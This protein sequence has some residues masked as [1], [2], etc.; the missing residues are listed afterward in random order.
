MLLGG[1]N[2]NR[3]CVF[4]DDTTQMGLPLVR[5]PFWVLEGTTS[6]LLSRVY[7]DD[8]PP[9]RGGVVCKNNHFFCV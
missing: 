1:L 6:A 3:S 8:C 9:T 7:E 5:V 4:V 2:E